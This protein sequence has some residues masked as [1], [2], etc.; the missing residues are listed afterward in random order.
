MMTDDT[1]IDT[2]PRCDQR[3][4]TAKKG[5]LWYCPDCDVSF[6]PRDVRPILERLIG[7]DMD[8]ALADAERLPPRGTADLVI[9]EW[10]DPQALFRL[11][12][13]KLDHLASL[14]FEG[15]PSLDV[16]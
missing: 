11:A 10:N 16:A 7:D 14:N 4:T 3:Q 1:R 12:H 8:V 6:R 13:Y 5:E 2:C 15:K 9:H